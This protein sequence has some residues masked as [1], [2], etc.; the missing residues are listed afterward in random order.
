MI[1]E[2]MARELGLSVEFTHLLARSASHRYYSFKIQKKRGGERTVDHPSRE[3]KLLQRWLVRRVFARLP[4]HESAYGY[5]AG[6]SIL[7]HAALHAPSNFIL[8]ADFRDFFPSIRG[9]DVERLLRHGSDSLRGVAE[10]QVDYS[11]IRLI[12]CKRDAL[13]VGAPSSPAISNA[14]MYEF[15]SYWYDRALRLGARYSRYADDLCFSTNERNLLNGLLDELRLDLTRRESPRLR[16]NDDK[17][18]FTSRKRLRRITGL[19]LTPTRGISI[20]RREKRKVKSLV[21]RS[22]QGNL[23]EDDQNSLRGLLSFIRSVEPSFLESLMKKY[24]RDAMGNLG[25]Y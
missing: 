4:V 14:V 2:M 19:V 24:G 22:T 9:I 11:A 21:F 5:I 1:L 12:V 25:I 7:H 10:G 23:S 15:D 13:A 16:L 18:V 8:K 3:L 6:K 20:G 17:T